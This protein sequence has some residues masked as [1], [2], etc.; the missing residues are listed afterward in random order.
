MVWKQ[1]CFGV[2]HCCLGVHGG[3]ARRHG[4]G[5]C[6]EGFRRRG[7]GSREWPRSS[8]ALVRNCCARRIA[9][10]TGGPCSSGVLVSMCCARR[11]ARVGRSAWERACRRRAR[12]CFKKAYPHNYILTRAMAKT[13]TP[14][15][16][17]DD[18]EPRATATD[19]KGR[20]ATT[21]DDADDDDERR[22]RRRRR[23]RQPTASTTTSDQRRR[24][25]TG[26]EQ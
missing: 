26:D 4:R 5:S 6:R 19:D 9:N 15:S 24:A 12:S 14:T 13:T 2:Q 21:S 8:G 23:R 1:R 10:R 17:D 25:V 7:L 20:P 22:R 3:A 16:D 11:I 18:D